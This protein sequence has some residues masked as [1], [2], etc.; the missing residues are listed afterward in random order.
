MAGNKTLKKFKDSKIPKKGTGKT[1]IEVPIYKEPNTKSVII[2]KIPK[3]YEITWISKS[4]CDEREWIRTDEKNNFG[5]IVGYEKDGKCNLDIN[6]L[7]E[8]KN[9]NDKKKDNNFKAIPNEFVPIT[10]E[11]IDIG[12][13]ALKEILFDDDKKDNRNNESQSI[14]TEI[15]EVN[16]SGFSDD[17][18]KIS[19]NK[20]E[21]NDKFDNFF[22][23]DD[24]S[25]IDSVVN[26]NNKLLNEILSQIEEENNQSKKDQKNNKESEKTDGNK[27]ESDASVYKALSSI[28]DVIPGKE[29][30]SGNNNL[31][32]ALNLIP[33]GK[34]SKKDAFNKDKNN[35]EEEDAIRKSKTIQLK[36]KKYPKNLGK[37]DADKKVLKEA[38]IAKNK[39]KKGKVSKDP[40]KKKKKKD[41]K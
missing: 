26:E 3:G 17:K 25:K 32:D 9:K 34:N 21:G 31:L 11:E 27:E 24:V 10:K 30:L 29:K 38:K 35:I 1:I 40:N 2:G 5:Y 23:E 13:E 14:S 16:K 18:N 28:L 33:G 15:D 7:K 12:N 41:N 22:F 39:D 6:S 36:G 20:K 4:I 8:N 19:E 37:E